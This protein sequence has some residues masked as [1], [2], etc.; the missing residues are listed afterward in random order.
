M[1]YIKIDGVT[2]KGICVLA[3]IR[4]NFSVTD[5]KNAGRSEFSGLMFRDIIGTFYNYSIT[6]D[7][8]ASDPTIYDAFYEKISAPDEKHEVVF[9][10][11]QETLTFDAYVTGGSDECTEIREDR[12]IWG[13]LSINFVAMKPQRTPL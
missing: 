3:P 10:Y 9:P 5:G 2:Y 13:N 1:D 7:A 6:V 4:R 11:G 12:K 8:S